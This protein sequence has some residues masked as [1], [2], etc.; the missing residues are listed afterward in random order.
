MWGE[1]VF[2][3]VGKISKRTIPTRVGRTSKPTENQPFHPDHP[4]AC[5]ENEQLRNRTL[6]AL[7][8]SPRVWG[9]HHRLDLGKLAERTIPTRVGRTGN[10]AA[11]QRLVSDH[12]HACG[13][14]LKAHLLSPGAAGPSPRVWGELS[15][16]V[17]VSCAVRTI[18]TRV[19][20][21]LIRRNKTSW[22]S[23]HPHACGE[24]MPYCLT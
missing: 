12:P 1:L 18:P 6:P 2:E 17:A 7:G 16:T 8:P 24:N 19:G 10:P 14:N 13:E 3:V 15:A 20:R 22:V 5:G 4:H 9:E 21:T 11:G 23:D